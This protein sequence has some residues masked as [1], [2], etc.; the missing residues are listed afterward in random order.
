MKIAIVYPYI[1]NK[2]EHYREDLKRFCNTLHQFPAGYEYDL[3]VEM[4]GGGEFQ[5]QDVDWFGDFFFSGSEYYGDGWDIG[6]H[7]HAAN[8]VPYEIDFMI[9]CCAHTFF[10][11]EG[12][13]NRMVSARE[14]FGPG[15]YGAMASKE[16]HP[17][18][19][20]CFFG[21]DPAD[22]RAFPT[23]INSR[24]KSLEFES[25]PD[26]FSL[27][28]Q[29]RGK[30]VKMVAWDGTYDLADCRKPDNVFRRGDQSNCLV[31][32]RHT[33]LYKAA[34]PEERAR[35]EAGANG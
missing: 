14:E 11:R 27:W 30:P 9:C 17:H 34:S 19:R 16:N 13:L 22:L 33:E 35:T 32:D 20:T 8:C 6:A 12:W 5:G 3:F 4:C 24:Q 29:R 10:H 28:M 18:I 25:G 23:V 26:N 2:A 1:C 31:W 7:Q 21:F 15:L